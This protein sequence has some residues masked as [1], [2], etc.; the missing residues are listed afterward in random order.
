MKRMMLLALI[1][2]ALLLSA[3]VTNPVTGESQFSIISEK[4]ELAMGAQ[5]YAPL[6]QSQGGD[7][8]VDPELTAYVSEVGQRLAKV[9]DRQLPYEFKV[10]NSGVPNAWALPGGK[11]VINRGLL[12]ELHN[13]AELAAVLGHEIT[14]AAARHTAVNMSKS[15]LLQGAAAGAVLATQSSEYG[16]IAQLGAGLGAQLLN[17]RFSRDAEREADYYGML[18]MSRAGYNPEGAVALQ[19]TFVRLS[20]GHAQGWLQGMFA[21]HPPSQERVLNN[22]ARLQALPMGGEFGE[23]RFLSKTAHL[24]ATKPAYEAYDKAQKALASGYTTQAMHLTERAIRLEPKEGHFYALLGDIEQ[25][26]NQYTQAIHAYTQATQRNPDFFYY[27]VQR[28]KAEQKLRLK[29]HA[30][31]DFQRGIALLPT[32]DAYYGL[33]SI[34]R[35]DNR[36]NDAKTYYAKAAKSPSPLGKMAYGELVELDLPSHPAQYITVQSVRLTDGRVAL[37]LQNRTPRS[38]KGVVVTVQFTDVSGQQR[39][40]NGTLPQVLAAESSVVIDLGLGQLTDER[41]ASTRASVIRAYLATSR[42]R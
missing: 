31:A 13:E 24:R 22:Q 40:L 41:M 32:A 5:Q 20:E 6:R 36:L 23:K 3:C 29:Q 27:Y 35:F 30:E 4:Q 15:I 2:W 28:G 10:L 38:V 12:T 8:V 39:Q 1:A 17:Q 25:Q 14:H 7:Y 18:Y 19:K 11:I 9:S 21:S 34:A 42:K 16:D 37:K 33:A 26:K